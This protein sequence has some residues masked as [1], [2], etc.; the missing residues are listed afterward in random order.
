MVS[1]LVILV[2]A[3][4]VTGL[5]GMVVLQ[6]LPLRAWLSVEGIF[7]SL[8]IGTVLGGWLALVLAEMGAFSLSSLL[9]VWLAVLLLLGGIAAA[10]LEST[11]ASY[12]VQTI[13]GKRQENEWTTEDGFFLLLLI[14]W[15]I[16]AFWLYFRPHEYIL[17]GADAGVYVSIGAEIA[18]NGG[19]TQQ[20]KVLSQLDPALQ[21]VLLR[22]LPGNPV[23]G[24]YLFPGFYVTNAVS[25]AVT[26][27]F[28]PLHPIWQAVA[29]SMSSSVE[30]GVRAELLITG[31]WMALASLAVILTTRE[32]GGRFAAVL[33]MAALAVAALQVWF[34]RYPTTEALTQFLM[35]S[36]IWATVRWL[37]DEKPPSLWALV[38]GSALG[39]VFL[40][41]IDML[42]L[43]PIFVV[44]VAGLWL[45]G[46]KRSDWWFLVPFSF[47]VFYSFFHGIVFSA[48]YFSEHIGYGLNLLLANWWIIIAGLL[49]GGS[50]LWLISR[51][52]DRHGE[53]ERY[54]APFLI[55][56]IAGFLA[57][58]IYGWFIRPVI[59]EATLRPDLYSESLLLITNHEN[60]RR[61]GWYL[62]A[63]GIW[64]AVAG[65]CLLIWRVESRTALLV[66]TGVVFSVIYLWNAQAN[67]HQI[68][69]MRRYVPVVAPFFL[70]AG[71]YFIS[72]AADYVYRSRQVGANGRLVGIITTLA[73]GALWLA[74][75]GWSAR[76]FIS[77]VD[78]KGVIE[79]LALI[80]DELPP[81]SVLLFYDQSPVGLGDFWG[82][83][84]KYLY[85][86]DAF[87]IRDVDL[88]AD[89]PLAETIE[90]WQNS[91]QP[92]VWIGD[93][94][95]LIDHDFD[96]EAHGFDIASTQMESSYEHKPQQIIPVSWRLEAAYIER[97]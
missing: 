8:T 29:F 38:G 5:G 68:Y 2:V 47:L 17:G 14:V 84:L 52:R 1:W 80:N 32:V 60:W 69:V 71:A 51:Y 3:L 55:L 96:F 83:P 89:A 63:P 49:I 77:Q 20:D 70:L 91:G 81:N 48:P 7:A 22:P 78:N 58:A 28:Y 90:F 19:I 15:L 75:L 53:L 93:P 36:G 87:T 54:R 64:L 25:G 11:A 86:H 57:Y 21:A 82:T 46:W 26:P 88:L 18:Q 73:V 43:L 27:Q 79:Q 6:F 40:V 13:S 50:A 45:R 31:M 95:W 74:L 94:T 10:R 76:G 4:T 24:S 92:V 33:V 65:I 16:A 39:A 37:G 85:G 59:N 34:A 42:V 12:E 23:A 67:P 72:K 66:A 30:Q 61:L 62:S 44:L 35:W 56:L 97:N 9:V 41:R